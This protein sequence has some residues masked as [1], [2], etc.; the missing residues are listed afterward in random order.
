M[1]GVQETQYVE[2]FD[3]IINWPETQELL[4]AARRCLG[5]FHNLS[6]LNDLDVSTHEPSNQEISHL[7]HYLAQKA[8][9]VTPHNT[10]HSNYAPSTAAWLD[11]PGP[12]N[13][14]GGIRSLST[15]T[16]VPSSATVR[17]GLS[18]SFPSPRP[19]PRNATNHETQLFSSISQP[20]PTLP[21]ESK[22]LDVLN[23]T[24]AQAQ[25]LHY[26]VNSLTYQPINAPAKNGCSSIACSNDTS[27]VDFPWSRESQ[28][29]SITT[30]PFHSTPHRRSHQTVIAPL[31]TSSKSLEDD[32]SPSLP[33]RQGGSSVVGSGSRRERP[34]TYAEAAR[35]SAEQV[36]EIPEPAASPATTIGSN[37]QKN[38]FSC[39]F[40]GCDKT[41]E[42]EWKF[43]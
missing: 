38:K 11:A 1:D 3:A 41:F 40:E 7:L 32:C 37:I 22:N 34:L 24:L 18:N 19:N 42:W 8:L 14:L 20:Q 28:K 27:Q 35:S 33:H 6:E 25:F 16:T 9:D 17:P 5:R 23:S 10:Q 12:W 29:T 4:S 21:A 13:P 43:K 15:E 30:P 39:D 26:G 31:S 36:P 2:G